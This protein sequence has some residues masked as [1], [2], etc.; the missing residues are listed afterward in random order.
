[1][2][3]DMKEKI[4]KQAVQLF[5]VKGY[6]NTSMR[7]IARKVGIQAPGIYHYFKSKQDILYWL[8]NDS[9][10]I[11]QEMVLNKIKIL[12]DPEEKIKL[13]ITE[14]IRFQIA[15]EEKNLMTDDS[16][17]TRKVKRRKEHDKE[18]FYFLRDTL[19]EFVAAKGLKNNI[20]LT[21]ATFALFAIVARVY[22]WYKPGGM[23]SLEEIIEQMIQLFLFGFYGS[24][25]MP[26]VKKN[27]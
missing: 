14:M 23:L 25:G 11:F 2:P 20:N 24:A 4:L 16:I 17:S 19:G 27:I 18:V 7:E 13:Y 8:D 26:K 15:M 5:I 22:R 6:E 10:Q 12:N 1:M 21:L 9:W 3:N